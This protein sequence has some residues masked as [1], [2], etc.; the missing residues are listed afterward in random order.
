ML[1][2]SADLVIFLE[3]LKEQAQVNVWDYEDF[4]EDKLADIRN[5][6]PV[7]AF[8]YGVASGKLQQVEYLIQ[9]IESGAQLVE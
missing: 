7:D 5:L 9:L 1:L 2:E 8:L 6:Q 4:H 3:R